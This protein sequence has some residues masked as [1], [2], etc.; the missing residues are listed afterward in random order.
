MKKYEVDVI[1]SHTI[2]GINA[3]SREE[4]EQLALKSFWK[5]ID[6]TKKD[7]KIIVRRLK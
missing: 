3:A 2:A 1:L 7:P 5:N 6:L 4:A